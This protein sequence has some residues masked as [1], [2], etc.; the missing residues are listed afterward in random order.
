MSYPPSHSQV[1]ITQRRS[2]GVLLINL[3]TPELPTPKAIHQFLAEFLMDP[4]VIEFPRWLWRPL[5]KIFIL[6]RRARRN[7]ALYQSIWSAE[8]SPLLTMSRQLSDGLLKQLASHMP[9]V[10]KVALGM[11]YGAPSIKQALAQLRSVQID[12]LLILPLYPQYSA[13]T[14]AS[15]FDAIADELKTWRR[16]PELRYINHYSDEPAYIEA[17]ATSIRTHWQ[18]H[19]K[20]DKLIFS[21]HGLPQKYCDLGDP[22]AVQCKKTADYLA[23]ALGL[24]ADSWMLCYQ[25]RFGRKAWLQPYTDQILKQLPKRGVKSVDIVCPGF[26]VD[27]LETL[28]EIDKTNRAIFL[29]AGGKGYHY[30][31]ALND[32]QSHLEMLQK[33]VEKHTLSWVDPVNL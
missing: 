22:Y 6:P 21:F 17:I 3:G 10:I 25:S 2:I 24:D 28:E 30:I 23:K 9:G 8:G 19:G 18:A 16:L 33:L 13:T 5:L 11:R 1:S 27:C 7:A 32:S 15:C 20:A 29:K 12:C 31:P 14:T 26:A 4:R